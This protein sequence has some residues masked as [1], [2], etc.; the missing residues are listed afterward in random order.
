[1]KYCKDVNLG[2]EEWEL[3]DPEWID[4]FLPNSQLRIFK[5]QQFGYRGYFERRCFFHS[6]VDGIKA[7]I[8][9]K[10]FEKENGVLP[11]TLT[12]LVPDYL[13]AYPVDYFN[14][15]ELN[16]T[17]EDRWLYSVG[18]NQ[19]DDYGSLQG[20]YIGKCE[21]GMECN[22]NPTIPL[23][24]VGPPENSDEDVSDAD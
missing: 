19:E 11:R 18:I 21:S 3:A 5:M 8:A 24:Y 12:E 6:Y 15:Q 23:D 1:M 14:G 7:V 9:I 22:N 20:V 17:S 4:F 10:K 13:P 16:Y 2:D